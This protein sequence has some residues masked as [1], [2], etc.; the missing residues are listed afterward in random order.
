MDNQEKLATFGTKDTGRRQTS[1]LKSR[2]QKTKTM[3]NNGLHQKL[4]LNP[5]ASEGQ[6]VTASYKTPAMFLI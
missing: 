3:S 6:T 1:N 4:G 2:T 5:G